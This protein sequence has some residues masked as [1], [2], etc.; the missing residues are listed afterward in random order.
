MAQSPQTNLNANDF[1]R[2]MPAKTLEGDRIQVEQCVQVESIEPVER[3][4]RS[5]PVPQTVEVGT[6]RTVIVS[7]PV[8]FSLPS[9]AE[10]LSKSDDASSQAKDVRFNQS[11]PFQDAPQV[12]EQTAQLFQASDDQKNESEAHGSMA[13]TRHTLPH[14]ANRELASSENFAPSSSIAAPQNFPAEPAQESS[15]PATWVSRILDAIPKPLQ[16]TTIVIR[17]E[18]FGTIQIHI[19]PGLPESNAAA[20]ITIR[21]SDPS[22]HAL[23][24]ES[25]GEIRQILK[26]EAVNIVSVNERTEAAA[27]AQRSS[28]EGSLKDSDQGRRQQFEQNRSKKRS[29][30][31]VFTVPEM[32]E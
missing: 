10:A 16:A 1:K 26:N 6:N 18:G 3:A 21:T 7:K 30:G 14:N 13:E 5:D 25:V 19:N 27:G 12:L 2:V 17:P 24:K 4:M 11:A 32:D 22:A 9:Q 8:E 31:E 28:H 20:R 29:G 23:L 15:L